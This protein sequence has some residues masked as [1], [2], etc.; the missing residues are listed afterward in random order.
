M[1]LNLDD[2]ELEQAVLGAI[3]L[4]SNTM[5]EVSPILEPC[6]FYDPVHARLYEVMQDMWDDRETIDLYTVSQ[7]TKKDKMFKGKIPYLAQLTQKVDSGM[8]VK[9]HAQHLRQCYLGR[10]IFAMG[11]QITLKMTNNNEIED[12]ISYTANQL[13][14]IMESATKDSN[15]I[16]M[17]QVISDSMDALCRRIVDFKEGGVAG[18]PSGLRGLDR[19]TGGWKGG[20]LIILAAR[21][22]V[23][24]SA[25]MLKFAKEASIT[26]IPV[27]IFSLEM[28]YQ[29]VGDRLIASTT[30]IDTDKY[31]AGD[32]SRD[33]LNDIE[34]SI[35]SITGLPISVN[36]NSSISMREI[37]SICQ[38]KKMK[39]ECGM[40][41]IDYLQ[42]VSTASSKK[43][44]REQEVAEITR[45]AKIMAK[46]LDVPVF[47]LCQLNRGIEARA[48][49]KPMLSDLR[50]SG[51][52]EQ[53]ANIVIFIDRP[54]M[55]GLTEIDSNS[56]GLISTDGL[57]RLV[58]GKNRD[59]GCGSVYFQHNP[60]LT[61]IYDYGA[62]ADK[63]MFSAL[64]R[65]TNTGFEVDTSKDVPF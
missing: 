51:S 18:I 58:V 39:G 20:Y 27:C 65:T 12:V 13:Q 14:E 11:Q 36:D 16:A 22:A 46:E 59:G 48:D 32:I 40:V 38:Q 42:L 1:G 52:I 33:E 63:K 10:Q 9:S 2:I 41:M 43:M 60:N 5:M 7:R 56:L 37:K 54:A 57:G 4:E 24:K 8:N 25:V 17:P 19:L 50:E 34:R 15:L 53:D 30:D 26:D 35:T 44:N 64:S 29:E 31:K 6:V 61:Q 23:G 21:P 47:L 55:Y 49:K 3:M 45:Q 28:T 62:Y